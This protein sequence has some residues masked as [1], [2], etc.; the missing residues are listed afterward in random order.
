MNYHIRHLLISLPLAVEAT[1]LREHPFTK[2]VNIFHL[3]SLVFAFFEDLGLCVV[4]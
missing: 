4:S 1:K 2:P 3:S